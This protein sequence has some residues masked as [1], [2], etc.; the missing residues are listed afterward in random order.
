MHFLFGFLLLATG[1]LSVN[2]ANEDYFLTAATTTGKQAF[3]Y[4][5]YGKA[6]PE[7]RTERGVL[8]SQQVGSIGT[9]GTT[10]WFR[11]RALP[12]GQRS[13]ACQSCVILLVTEAPLASR[14]T[15]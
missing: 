6:T 14:S 4:D 5:A 11:W 7:Q 8:P 10:Y 9:S 15:T 12:G 13:H 2:A 1:W 3:D